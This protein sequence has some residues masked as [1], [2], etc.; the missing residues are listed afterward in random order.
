[1]GLKEFF[2]DVGTTIS[3]AADKAMTK[4]DTTIDVAKLKKEIQ[5][6]QK[7]VYTVYCDLGKAIIENGISDD[8]DVIIAESKEKIRIINSEIEELE[9]TRREKDGKCLC[10]SCGA[11]LLNTVIF[12]SSCGTKIKEDTKDE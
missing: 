1:M 6:K 11:E 7:E 3:N 12:C 9:K 4:V 10:P 2:K 5:D 8:F